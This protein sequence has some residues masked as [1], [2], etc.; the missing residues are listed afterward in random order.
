MHETKLNRIHMSPELH[1]Y[2]HNNLIH[3]DIQG[4]NAENGKYTTLLT[5]RNRIVFVLYCV[6]L[7][8]IV[9][10]CIVLYC[11][12]LYCI[13]LYCIVLYCIVLRCGLF[14]PISDGIPRCNV[15][16]VFP[17]AMMVKGF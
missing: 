13:V 9:L 16:Q 10:Y 1:G 17:S 2:I 4:G 14:F 12:V 8:C 15:I 6:V 5:Y 11:I 3:S 7:Y